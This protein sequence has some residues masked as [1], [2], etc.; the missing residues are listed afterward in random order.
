MHS[1]CC[2]TLTG[3]RGPTG[4]MGSPG[5]KGPQGLPGPWGPKGR[6]GPVGN[7]GEQVELVVR[8]SACLSVYLSDCH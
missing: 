5:P 4:D 3:E 1:K 8:D 6:T 7:I 2:C